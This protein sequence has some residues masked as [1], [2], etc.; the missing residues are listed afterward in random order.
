M[1]M[2]K[3]KE[4][5]IVDATKQIVAALSAGHLANTTSANFPKPAEIA[6]Q[7]YQIAEATYERLKH[8]GWIG[9]ARTTA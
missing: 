8:L 9:R 1:D 6:D 4:V 5:F 2:V 3:E 7:A